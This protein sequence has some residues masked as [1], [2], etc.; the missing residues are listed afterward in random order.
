MRGRGVARALS[1]LA[2]GLVVGLMLSAGSAAAQCEG[3]KVS[4]ASAT[5]SWTQNC[6]W[7]HPAWMID[8]RS[9]TAWALGRCFA[10]GDETPGA[11]VVF[12]TASDVAVE[13]A[14]VVE[15][16]VFSGGYWG[17]CGGGFTTLGA[18]KVF[19]TDAD[20]STFAD[21]KVS[22]GQIGSAWYEVEVLGIETRAADRL[23][24]ESLAQSGHP[25]WALS[26][27][28][29]VLVTGDNPEYAVY[30]IRA[31]SPVATLR[32]VRLEFIDLNGAS[33]D[34]VGALPTGGPG[35]HANGNVIVREVEVR[36]GREFE[37]TWGPA[38]RVLCPGSASTLSVG[39]SGAGPF[40]Y[41]WRKDGVEIPGATG[42]T[43]LIG[44]AWAGSAG[45]YDCVVRNGA[46]VGACERVTAGATVTV[47]FADF[48]CDGEVG[49]SDFFDWSLAFENG[50]ARSDTNGDGFLDWFDFADFVDAWSGGCG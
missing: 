42:A 45:V 41:Q 46:G 19:V 11:S 39:V 31:K 24:N 1:G 7:F 27:S 48:D 4:L 12:E 25:Q 50:E 37:V 28:G 14:D 17:C 49:P 32:G 5:A 3:V 18:F 29:E 36:V 22:G 26:P 35:R 2:A 20:R 16:R 6:F 10:G 33:A 23:G 43:Y 47:C 15:F 30:R 38:S 40:S 44:S 8:G 21:G 34:P 13:P 9:D